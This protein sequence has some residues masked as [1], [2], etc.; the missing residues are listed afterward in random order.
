MLFLI[1][2]LL[3][4]L[5]YSNNI[6]CLQYIYIYIYIYTYIYI[7]IYIYM[8][9]NLNKKDFKKLTK[10]KLIRLL[11][12]QEKERQAKKPSDSIN[13]PP[14][15]GKRESVKPKPIPRKSVNE[16]EDLILPSP[17]QFQD[18]H[19]P[20]PKPS[21]DKSLQMQNARRPPKPK[22]PPPPPPIKEHEE[23]IFITDVSV[24]MIKEL[25]LALNP[26]QARLF[27]LFKGPRGGL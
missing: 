21:T 3:S 2:E 7:Y 10:A 24:P 1:L 22:R 6:Y 26:I 9:M 15:T 13:K 25:N 4:P 8:N 23:P 14:R 16:Y 19:K 12:K 18:G 17:E 27:L 11:L 20:I 5:Y